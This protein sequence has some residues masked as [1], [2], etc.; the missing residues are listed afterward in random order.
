MSQVYC[1]ETQYKTV[2]FRVLD[3]K[4]SL[5]VEGLDGGS[6]R[7]GSG[8]AVGTTDCVFGGFF[9]EADVKFHKRCC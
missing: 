2:I 6:K 4:W 7:I 1:I 9:T 5:R 3:N 8:T